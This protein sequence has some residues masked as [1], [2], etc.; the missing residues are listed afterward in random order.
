MPGVGV[1]DLAARK[2]GVTVFGVR[3][4]GGRSGLG[5]SGVY[6]FRFGVSHMS[7]FGKS[8]ATLTCSKSSFEDNY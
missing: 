5:G 8:V 7:I 2:V 4:Q 6:L 3:G 1:G